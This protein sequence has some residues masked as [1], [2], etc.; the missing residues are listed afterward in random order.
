M[1]KIIITLVA[2][3]LMASGLWAEK[4]VAYVCD[5]QDVIKDKCKKGDFLILS[6]DRF[7]ADTLE[8]SLSRYFLCDKE[9]GLLLTAVCIYN[10][11]P[12]VEIKRR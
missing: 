3:L 6:N 4:E 11:N 7:K 2:S 9:E 1:K 8:D 5:L 12:W 10:G